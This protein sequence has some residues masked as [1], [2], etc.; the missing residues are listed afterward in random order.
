M[1]SAEPSG[2][3][4][5]LHEDALHELQLITQLHNPQHPDHETGPRNWTTF[6]SPSWPQSGSTPPTVTQDRIPAALSSSLYCSPCLHMTAHH[7]V[8][9]KQVAGAIMVGLI[10]DRAAVE[11]LSCWSSEN[12]LMLNVHET[13]EL[14]MDLL[15]VLSKNN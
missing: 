11:N 2:E 4:E 12:N 14:I 5:E 10:S 7:T 13:K 15:R 3:Q 6:R 9:V 8:I 1:F